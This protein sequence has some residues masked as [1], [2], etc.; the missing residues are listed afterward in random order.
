MSQRTKFFVDIEDMS[1]R[2]K[3]FDIGIC[4]KAAVHHSKVEIL[5]KLTTVSK[6]LS[7]LTL[8]SS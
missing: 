7:S 8:F 2:T 6:S 5:F 4:H 1:Q 3:I